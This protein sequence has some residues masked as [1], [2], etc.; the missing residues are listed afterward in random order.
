MIRVPNPHTSCTGMSTDYMYWWCYKSCLFMVSR[1][2]RKCLGLLTVI[3]SCKIVMITATKDTSL[4]LMLVIPS[5][6]KKIRSDLRFI[7][8]WIKIDKW[9]KLVCNMNGK[10]TMPCV[11]LSLNYILVLKKLQRVI[12]FN[13][14]AWLK[15]H[16]EMNIA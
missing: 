11:K 4:M 13:Q 16:I 10:K 2:K 1:R 9:Q 6:Y 3:D 14:E 8:E 12:E 5:T 15:P 7:A